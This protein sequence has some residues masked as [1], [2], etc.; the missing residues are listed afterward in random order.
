MLSLCIYQ[1]EYEA[2]YVYWI[3]WTCHTLLGF[4][5]SYAVIPYVWSSPAV[6]CLEQSCSATHSDPLLPT[7][8]VWLEQPCLLRWQYSVDW[9]FSFQCSEYMYIVCWCHDY[10]VNHS[11]NILTFWLKL[12]PS[13]CPISV[14]YILCNR[15]VLT[16]RDMR[17]SLWH[18]ISKQGGGFCLSMVRYGLL[19]EFFMELDLSPKMMI[20]HP[21]WINI[22]MY[23]YVIMNKMSLPSTRTKYVRMCLYW[24]RTCKHQP[25]WYGGFV[26]QI[27]LIFILG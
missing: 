25:D 5:F 23:L 2:H 1:W 15:I 18:K 4:F 8:D 7:A 12:Y 10:F 26:R 3:N 24:L 22:T 11:L 14:W 20:C 13:Y 21:L 6:F 9:I 17:V 27:L 16:P 19:Q